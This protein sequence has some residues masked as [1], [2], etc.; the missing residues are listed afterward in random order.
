MP[1]RNESGERKLEMCAE[2][3]LVVDSSWF[4]KKDVYKHMDENGGK[5][6]GRQGIDGLCVDTK[7]NAWKTVKCGSMER[8]RWRNF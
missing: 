3:E 8:K 4:K 7:T 1:G 6:G 5:K 2:Q